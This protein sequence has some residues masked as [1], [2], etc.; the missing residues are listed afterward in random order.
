MIVHCTIIVLNGTLY[1]F[2]KLWGR[3]RNGDFNT[4]LPCD[5]KLNA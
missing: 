3:N 4:E 2:R 5:P 1:T